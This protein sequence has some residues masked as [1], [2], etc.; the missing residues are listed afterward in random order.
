MKHIK[1]IIFF[2]IT[3]YNTILG[4]H[5]KK[6][7]CLVRKR[8]NFV[9]TVSV[10]S[11]LAAV[12]YVARSI[13]KKI[14]GGESFSGIFQKCN[15]YKDRIYICNEWI[16]KFIVP[17]GGY[18]AIGNFF[19]QNNSINFQEQ[20]IGKLIMKDTLGLISEEK[21]TIL[22]NIDTSAQT[23][24]LDNFPR[25]YWFR[26]LIEKFFYKAYVSGEA[27]K[28][29]KDY[30]KTIEEIE[31]AIQNFTGKDETVLN[32]QDSELEKNK[33]DLEIYK[34]KESKIFLEKFQFDNIDYPSYLKQLCDHRNDI[35]KKQFDKKIMVYSVG[36][37]FLLGV[38]TYGVYICSFFKQYIDQ[39]GLNNGNPLMQF[40]Y[41]C[42]WYFLM[43][44]IVTNVDWLYWSLGVMQYV[45]LPSISLIFLSKFSTYK[46]NN[47]LAYN[48]NK[49]GAWKT[50]VFTLWDSLSINYIKQNFK[51][52]SN[53]YHDILIS[54]EKLKDKDNIYKVCQMACSIDDK[55]DWEE[56]VHLKSI[57]SMQGL[58][59]LQM[60][61]IILFYKQ[62]FTDTANDKP[63]KELEKTE[64]PN[65]R[66]LE[67][68]SILLYERF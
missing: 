60:Y 67:D 33:K 2:C 66:S 32:L 35:L 6:C 7:L 28:E 21:N 17:A 10:L 58:T 27:N 45:V 20:R 50:S 36:L 9:L 22:N 44:I 14:L 15:L 61:K 53:T 46:Y 12:Y 11:T 31:Y 64:M 1:F 38:C 47:N 5:Y 56:R 52:L 3:F 68:L 4:D 16:K 23:D 40:L 51:D 48:L 63:V 43:K 39:N 57:V 13:N 41:K 19:N 24:C 65:I 8:N 34:N 42:K 37:F 30:Y 26:D 25:L 55:F 59:I 18:L 29:A 62:L 54:S 49:I